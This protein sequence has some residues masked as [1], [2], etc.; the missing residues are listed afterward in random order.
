[1]QHFNNKRDGR[2]FINKG[3]PEKVKVRGVGRRLSCVVL[4]DQGL[5]ALGN[6]NALLV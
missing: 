5:V 2:L 3:A 6:G 1:M 4:A